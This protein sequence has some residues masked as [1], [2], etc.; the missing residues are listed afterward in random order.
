MHIIAAPTEHQ[1]DLTIDAVVIED[2]TDLVLGSE[3]VARQTDEAPR[4]LL[5]RAAAA[6]PAEPGT[7]VVRGG[8]PLRLHA[9]VHDLDL[10]PSWREAWIQSA[11]AAVLREVEMRRLRVLS[12]PALGSVHGELRLDRFAQMLASTLQQQPP[13]QL[14][15]VWLVIPPGTSS[16][17]L[18][19]LRELGLMI[20]P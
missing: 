16:A 18:T 13:G 17:T 8:T 2:D 19:P 12:L 10:E 11:L 15:A 1:P 6:R 7:V 3:P 4:R 9:V 14:E 5:K 20:R